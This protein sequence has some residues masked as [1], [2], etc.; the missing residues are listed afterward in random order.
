MNLKLNKFKILMMLIAGLFSVQLMAQSQVSGN[1]SDGDMPLIGATVFVKGTSTGTVTDI[2]GTFTIS[3]N[4]GDVLSVS[5]TGFTTEDITIGDVTS[6]VNVVLDSGIGLD[7]I[8]VTGYSVDSRRKTAGSVSTVA[9]RDLQVSPSGNVEQQLQGRVAGVTVITNGQPGTAS[10][11]RV[12]GF[13]AL[14]GNA[15]LYVVDGVPV[16]DINFLSP[17]DIETTTVLKDATA[18]SI[19]GARAASGVIIYTTKKGKRN[20]K[21]VKITYDG[22][23]GVTTPGNGP[24]V[25]NPQEQADWT[26]AAIR[27]AAQQEGQD[28]EFD[29]RQYGQGSTP[30]IP[31]YLL[32]GGASGVT[33]TVNLADHVDSYNVDPEAGPIYQVVKANQAGTDWYDAIT[34]N[35]L[36]VRHNLGFSGGGERSR[37]YVGLGMQ[38]QE[39]IVKHQKFSRYNM[40]VNTE[41]DLFPTLRIGQNVQMTY[42]SARVLLGDGGGSGS[43]DDENIV[44]SASRMSP[45]IPV[46]DE[47][48][49]Y[50]GTAAPGFNNPANPVAVLDGAQND[51]AFGVETFGNTYLEFE[52]IK[53]LVARTSFGG[54]FQSFNSRAYSRRTYENQENNS[55]FGYSQNSSVVTSWVLTNTLSYK[56]S[57]GTST[58]SLLV[59]QEAL[60][61]GSSRS[62]SGSGINPFSQN[63]DFV[64][65]STVGS[66]VVNGGH[67]DGVNFASY[68]GRVNYD[69]NDKYIVSAVVRRDGSSRFGAEDRYGVFP[70]FSAAWRLSSEDFMKDI[71][72]ID[73]LKLRGGYGI[74]G[75]SN[76]VD[77]NNQFSLFG[78]SIGASSYDING[79][80]TSAAQGFYRTRIGNPLAKWEKAITQNIG[81]DAILFDGKWDV[82]VE[83]WRKETEDLLF[84][85]PVTVQ[86]GGFASAPSVNIGKM[87]NKGVDIQITHKN[88]K[89]ELRYEIGIV[90][91][92]LQNKIVELA[93]GIDNLP[94]RSNN[95]R[96]ITPI[97]NQVGQPISAF[98]GY[99]VEGIFANDAEVNGAAEQEGAAPGRFRFKDIDS[100]DENGN[101]T[102]VPD[103]IIDLADRTT[104]GNPV[105]DFTGGLTVKLNYRNWEM[106]VYSFASIGNE[107]YNVSKVFTDFYPLFPG[108]AIGENVKDSWTFDNP[109]GDTPL[110]ENTS[111]FS[112]NTQSNS[113][114]VEDGS[115][116][117]L[118]NLTI[119]Y[120][121][122]KSL[123]GDLKMS[124]FKVFASVNN[125]FTLTKYSGLDP[126]VGGAAD[127]N[128]GVDLGNYPI[129][130]SWVFGV[131]VGF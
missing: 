127:T 46:Y 18:A 129:T 44:L 84:Q 5:Y 79:T 68:F 77:P 8:V 50:A 82:G 21:G 28:P 89:G 118:Q 10:Q 106:E 121:L 94:N 107:I 16:G 32:V 45:I 20:T 26:W 92:F 36:L 35:A 48:G 124:K 90:G 99:E 131:N 55:S 15:P 101:L 13:G 91:G 98:Y 43:S 114:Y 61:T 103:N 34:R 70:A 72:F 108:A 87:E 17:D 125:L 24:A 54:R 69:L 7:E 49:G 12:R 88:R 33:G 110:F 4:A 62:M 113:Y 59:G 112:T 27:N 66:T 47:F 29:H 76:N 115:Y 78:T 96:G 80:N 63:I 64:G 130:R 41:F 53:N 14:G 120:H 11:V 38:E 22:M 60:N 85:L 75:N 52:P 111:N 105:P 123:L 73:D 58:V 86:A 57:F 81:I 30:V 1:V 126:S 83:L 3:A 9:A 71:S 65:L 116:F 31:D 122:P 23:V 93:P 51:R 117:R 39:G 119:G 102:G 100:Y 56:K 128:F 95:Y 42:R 19:Y 6:P 104:L 97:L 109:T 74:M 2:D 40:R 25:L 37:F 67:T